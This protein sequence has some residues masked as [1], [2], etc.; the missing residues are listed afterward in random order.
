MQKITEDLD[1]GTRN[2]TI[3]RDDKEKTNPEEE[4]EFILCKG[5]KKCF[6]AKKTLLNQLKRER[7]KKK[8]RV[9]FTLLK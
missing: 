3:S 5:D 7:D 8:H 2:E 6:R 9:V 4:E 1:K